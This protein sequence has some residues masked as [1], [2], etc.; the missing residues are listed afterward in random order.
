MRATEF[1]HDGEVPGPIKKRLD[2]KDEVC[3]GV[4]SCVPY[5][6]ITIG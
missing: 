4:R 6:I 3:K 1:S 5:V 2:L